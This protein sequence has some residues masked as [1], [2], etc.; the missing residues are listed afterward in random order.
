MTGSDK[1][2]S[3]QESGGVDRGVGAKRLY[4]QNFEVHPDEEPKM[5]S[6]AYDGVMCPECGRM[7]GGGA[8]LDIPYVDEPGT[9]A[10]SSTGPAGN[11]DG[12]SDE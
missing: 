7:A 5:E 10:S 4:C 6:G 11:V 1:R 2:P 3:R 8:P 9:P 12:G